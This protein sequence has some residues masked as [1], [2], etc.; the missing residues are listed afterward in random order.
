MSSWNRLILVSDDPRLALALEQWVRL[1]WGKRQKIQISVYS[2]EQ[3][4]YTLRNDVLRTDLMI[5]PS[6]GSSGD[7]DLPIGVGSEATLISFPSQRE[8]TRL[9]R[10]DLLAVLR[11]S[12]DVMSFEEALKWLILQALEKTHG[13]M[14]LAAQLL[15]I[16]RATLYRR[17]KKFGFDIEMIRDNLKTRKR[18]SSRKKAA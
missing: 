10:Q 14:K 13:N 5:R 12:L 8:T 6:Q 11:R 9:S 3:W 16:G 15:G 17:M 2:W 1:D 7:E 4:Q 18:K